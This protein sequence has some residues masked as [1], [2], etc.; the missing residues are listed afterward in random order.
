MSLAKE[1]FVSM[2]TSNGEIHQIDADAIVIISGVRT[3]IT[4]AKKGVCL[5]CFLHRPTHQLQLSN[6]MSALI[7]S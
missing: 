7:A 1:K 2:L 6:I 4:K 5:C 3:P